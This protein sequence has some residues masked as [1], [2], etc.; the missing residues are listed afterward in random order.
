M[1]NY[2][3]VELNV[4]DIEEALAESNIEIAQLVRRDGVS[5]PGWYW[6]KTS[7]NLRTGKMKGPYFTEEEAYSDAKRSSYH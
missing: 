7:G 4:D 2:F 3:V 5:L 1:M 6:A